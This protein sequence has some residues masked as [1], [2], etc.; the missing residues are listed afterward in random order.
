MAHLGGFGAFGLSVTSLYAF[1]GI[2]LPCPFRM[3]TGWDCPLC[4]GTRMGRALLELDIAAAFA[5]N[6]VVLIGLVV[7][8]LLGV[9][10]TVEAIGGPALRPPRQVTEFLGKIS[11]NQGLIIGL[12][13]ATIYTFARN[14]A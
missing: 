5:F 9:A 11:A 14:L 8:T 7:L 1:A 4:G 12:A 6:P 2:G 10:W 3:V 13:A